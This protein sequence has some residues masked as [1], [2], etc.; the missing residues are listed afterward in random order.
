LAGSRGAAGP[1]RARL[2]VAAAIFYIVLWASAYVPSKVGATE[3][4]PY[5]FL[6]VRF[7]LAGTLMLLI[8]LV[9]RRPFPRDARAWLAFAA[10]G[11]FANAAYLGFTYTALAHGLSSGVGAI[12]ASTNP[13]ILALVAPWILLEP[14]T[15]LKSLGLVLG[16]GG[17]IA[18][19]LARGG[20]GTAAPGDVALAVAGVVA[21]VISTIVFK[22][23]RGGTDLLAINAIGLLAAG[24]VLVPI[25]IA[26]EGR[27]P[28][29][30]FSDRTLQIA[31]LYLVAVMSVGASLIWFTLLSRGEASRVS[32]YYFLTPAFG[33]AFGAMLL[34]EPVHPADA[35][36]LGAIAAG[37]ILVQRR[38]PAAAALSK[39]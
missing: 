27:L 15:R 8:A 2:G 37:I 16:F 13:L 14:L 17:V 22:R 5:W 4:P 10:L 25:A 29:E 34:R 32:A 23:A 12:V 31:M 35:I 20:S 36:G 11:I 30:R 3:S 26:F 6:V 21:S 38:E 9:L 7:L 28:I 24:L 33:L 18:I 19:V 1:G 39:R